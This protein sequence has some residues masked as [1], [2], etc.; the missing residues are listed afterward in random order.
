MNYGKME[1]EELINKIEQASNDHRIPQRIRNVLKRIS[2]DLKSDPKDL[3]VKITSAVYELDDILEDINI[4][5]HAKT[6]LWDIISDLEEISK[7]V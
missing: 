6:V 1:L 3:S 4:P 7:E 5:M 2:K